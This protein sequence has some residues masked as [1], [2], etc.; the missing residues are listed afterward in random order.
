MAVNR[1]SPALGLLAMVI[2]LSSCEPARSPLEPA[3][4]ALVNA[5]VVT[6][7]DA[8]PSGEAVAIRGQRIVAVGSRA[9][10]EPFIASRT[11]VIDL[12]GQ[13]L[14]PGFIE[15]HGHFM[16]VGDAQLILDLRPPGTWDE[17]VSMVAEAVAAA[18]PGELIRGRGWHQDEWS[19]TPAGAIEGFPVHDSLS[20][21]S[22]DN[23]VV[24]THAS[25]HAALVNARAL[26]LAGIAAGTP[27][28]PGGEILRDTDG[29]ATGLLRETA[30]GLVRGEVLVHASGGGEEITPAIARRM[31]ELAS[32]EALSNGVTTFTD[33]GSSFETID[34]LEQAATEGL[35][36]VRLWVMVRDSNDKL[37]ER[38]ASYK[39]RDLAGGML[40]VGGIKLSIDGALGSR[41]AWLLEPYADLP[42]STGLNLIPLDEARETAELAIQHGYQLAIHAIGDRANREVLDLYEQTFSAHPDK[43]DLRWRVEHAQHL[44]PDDI[45]RF[46]A[47]GV[48]ASVQG[49]HCTSDASW[50]PDR[51]GSQRSRE[52]AYVWRALADAGALIVNGTDVPV[53]PIDPIASFY[54]SVSRRLD[55]GSVFYPEQRMERLEAL[56]TYTL[57][58]AYAIRE[59]DSRGSL[60]PGKLADIVV[61]SRN[62]LEVPEEE[63]LQAEVIYTILGGEIVYEAPVD[64]AP[65][66]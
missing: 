35:L 15:G 31:V 62:I 42:S 32:Q 20:A 65:R 66:G 39:V 57:N 16:G 23:P 43:T 58:A 24:L 1:H 37:A 53:E 11:R 7:D 21:V 8:L 48:I 55:D 4:L 17:I 19:E 26:E 51:L 59:E 44:H 36:G 6:L 33:A 2:L 22:P 13:L 64:E 38:L 46:A 29:R 3:D 50:V 54:A 52:G 14:V 34:V 45:G 10:I 41:G 63:I 56:R 9:D 18:E 30:Q 61:L 12:R 47:L 25:G 27:N 28:P 5:V 40:S 49:I 60:T